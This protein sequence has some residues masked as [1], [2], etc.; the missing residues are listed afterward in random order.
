[1]ERLPDSLQLSCPESRNSHTD[2]AYFP[3]KEQEFLT[4]RHTNGVAPSIG[5]KSIHRLL[6]NSS[7][8]VI[9]SPW[10]WFFTSQYR[11]HP[12]DYLTPFSC[13]LLRSCN[14]ICY[15]Q[16]R[17][18]LRRSSHTDGACFPWK[19][20]EFL[21]Y[22]PHQCSGGS[23]RKEE[24]SLALPPEGPNSVRVTF[25]R[26]SPPM[27]AFGPSK[28]GAIARE[29]GLELFP[30]VTYGVANDHTLTGHTNGVA[31]IGE[32]SIHRLF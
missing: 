23:H 5:E 30:S 13:P 4:Y 11:V 18:F 9:R 28:S 31:L 3:G 26:R 20:Q 7:I 10:S 16:S 29:T 14:Q 22:R 15:K 27:Q 17:L 24:D 25:S 19:E 2:G 1:M 12:K 8:G 6:L 32:K 21:A